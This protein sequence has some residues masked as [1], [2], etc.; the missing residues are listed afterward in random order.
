MSLMIYMRS[1]IASA[2]SKL[3]KYMSNSLEL[4]WKL[5][6]WILIYTKNTINYELLFDNLFYNVEILIDYMYVDYEYYLDKKLFT[7]RYV[8]TLFGGCISKKS[9]L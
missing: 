4:H 6:K 8:L 7:T 9:I 3:I 2:I 5:V 1:Y